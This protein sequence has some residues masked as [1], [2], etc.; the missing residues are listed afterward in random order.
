MATLI[1][2]Y[3]RAFPNVFGSQ[4]VPVAVGADARSEAVTM[5]GS[6]DLTAAPGEGIVVLLADA[7]CWVAVGP[8]PDTSADGDGVRAAWPVPAGAPY[9]LLV[10][11]G[12]GIAVEAR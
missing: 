9:P 6:S 3:S 5:P 10:A 4:V 11:E 7:D 8:D 12:D 1:V 2:T